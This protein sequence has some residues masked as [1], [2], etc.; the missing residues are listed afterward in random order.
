M[1]AEAVF[2]RCGNLRKVCEV[3]DSAGNLLLVEPYAIFTSIKK[4]K[5]VHFYQLSGPG[6]EGW[7]TPESRDLVAGRML[8]D[9][10]TPRSGYDP[11]DKQLFPV[12]HYSI[13]THDG[14][15][16]WMDAQPG[17]TDDHLRPHIED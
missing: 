6:G 11:F 15:Q 7:K 16:R 4:R 17:K 8:E 2:M 3:K 5:H 10:F 12:M 1:S 9:T 13:P 14:R